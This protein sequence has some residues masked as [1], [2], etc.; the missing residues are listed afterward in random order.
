M[1]EGG[2]ERAR[3]A[4]WMWIAFDAMDGKRGNGGG[5]WGVS[6][7]FFDDLVRTYYSN[8]FIRR[9]SL[10][11][12]ATT[13]FAILFYLKSKREDLR[14]IKH[15]WGVVG[16][17]LPWSFVYEIVKRFRI[18]RSYPPK[19]REIYSGATCTICL[20]YMGILIKMFIFIFG[21]IN[22]HQFFERRSNIYTAFIVH[23]FV[24]LLHF[25]LW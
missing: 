14:E 3:C 17:V 2:G 10:G 1:E 18:P 4:I 11:K 6:F 24:S 23:L 25:Y 5:G 9:V 12:I 15:Y 7:G 20:K 13:Y 16:T 8:M 21:Q 19:K 22:M